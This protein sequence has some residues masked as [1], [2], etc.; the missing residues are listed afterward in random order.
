M[1]RFYPSSSGGGGGGGA[2]KIETPAGD[3]D[4][5][6]TIFTTVH[7]PKFMTVNGLVQIENIDYVLTG[8]GPYT[9]TFTQAPPLTDPPTILRS[10]Y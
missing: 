4:G 2:S 1:P 10:F 7:K 9:E 5:S 6:N 3:I 8:T